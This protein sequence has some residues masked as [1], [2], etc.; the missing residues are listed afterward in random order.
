MVSP[1][2][3]LSSRYRIDKVLGRGGMGAVYLARQQALADRPVAVKEMELSG[4][5]PN[6]QQQAVRQFHREASFLAHLRHP[7]LVR[8]TDVF[9]EHNRHYLVM[10]Y[11]E[12]RSLQDILAQ[13][14]DPFSWEQVKPWALALADV[15]RY[16]HAQDPPILF[17]DLKP[18]N[19]MISDSGKLHLIDFG[20]AR[21]ARQG[22]VT[23]TFLR[24]A[25]S[26]GYSPIEQYGNVESTDQRSDIYSL[27]A[28]LYTLLTRVITPDAVARVSDEA[29]LL[30]PSQLNPNLPAE[31]DAVLGRALALRQ[32]DRY[33]TVTEFSRALEEVGHPA[34]PPTSVLSETTSS[35]W[36]SLLA[37]G[38][39]FV[40][41]LGLLMLRPQ[42]DQE[43]LQ[44]RIPAAQAS[45]SA[46]RERDPAVAPGQT[47]I[48]NSVPPGLPTRRIERNRRANVRPATP[49]QKPP[50][51]EPQKPAPPR[52]PTAVI[53]SDYPQAKPS[54]PHS[55][56]PPVPEKPE[57]TLK[58]LPVPPLP[59]P[60]KTSLPAPRA[61]ATPP[62]STPAPIYVTT[63]MLPNSE[64]STSNPA[65]TETAVTATTGTKPV[66]QTVQP[67]ATTTGNTPA[68][69][70]TQTVQAQVTT[71]GATQPLQTTQLQATTTS[72]PP[73]PQ[74]NPQSPPRAASSTAR[75]APPPP[76]PPN[77]GG[78]G[79][80]RGGQGRR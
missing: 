20:I 19:V 22:S 53:A 34:E 30:L 31:L 17:R 73:P 9:S 69:Q 36:P 16:L 72:P 49:I 62:P 75:S 48:Q 3:V 6:E 80:G 1:G 40:L 51:T 61:T 5:E 11:I 44:S 79:R 58:R 10:E 27:G 46:I 18:S 26:S 59:V 12:G 56:Q 15:L 68:Q 65:T 41:G 29:L 43:T 60:T 45:D 37:A 50:E 71:T 39:L 28:T 67:Q 74:S 4:L 38:S 70:T 2:T 7:N 13:R 14:R 64:P 52:Q 76:P 78:G 32:R 21:R 33:Q 55:V 35:W 47:F 8:V 77:N 24:G 25:G 57:T 63:T 42:I 66:Q 54:V 23:S